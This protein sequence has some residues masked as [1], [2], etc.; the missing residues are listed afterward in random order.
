LLSLSTREDG[1]QPPVVK[2]I[3]TENQGIDELAAAIESYRESHLKTEVGSERR[4]AMARWRILE[5]LRERLVLRTLESDSAAER[6]DQLAA[7]VATRRRDPYSAV[8]EI[9]RA[10]GR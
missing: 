10:A 7:E 8:E 3:A 5:L 4:R 1:W 9:I 6:L 2:T